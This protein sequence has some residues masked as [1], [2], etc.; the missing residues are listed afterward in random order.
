[1]IKRGEEVARDDKGLYL[2]LHQI[3]PD[4]ILISQK[5]CT[6]MEKTGLPTAYAFERT[7]PFY[8]CF[9]LLQ[10][11]TSIMLKSEAKCLGSVDL[12]SS[13]ALC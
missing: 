7:N 3:K 1:M 10:L 4:E 13:S 12:V 11:L 8:Q 5:R 2:L 9:P 6:E